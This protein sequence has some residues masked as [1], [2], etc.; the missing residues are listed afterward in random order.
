MTAFPRNKFSSS[1]QFYLNSGAIFPFPHF[2]KLYRREVQRK[3][4][5]NSV[6]CLTNLKI[7]YCVLISHYPFLKNYDPWKSRSHQPSIAGVN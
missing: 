5:L 4:L 6:Y 1:G 2:I 3:I 7:S